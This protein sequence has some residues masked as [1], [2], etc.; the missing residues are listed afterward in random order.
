[1]S[2]EKER[3]SV[4]AKI[5]DG[6]VHDSGA[7]PSKKIVGGKNQVWRCVANS[8]LIETRGVVHKNTA[9]GSARV[10]NGDCRSICSVRKKSTTEYASGHSLLNG[11]DVYRVGAG[12]QR[13]ERKELIGWL[14]VDVKVEGS[15]KLPRVSD[16]EI[17]T[18]SNATASG[19]CNPV[20]SVATAGMTENPN[21]LIVV[22]LAGIDVDVK[23][24][25]G[26]G[27]RPNHRHSRQAESRSFRQYVA[28]KSHSAQNQFTRFSCF[29]NPELNISSQK[30]QA[31]LA[32][33]D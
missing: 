26:G 15:V 28:L 14:V 27:C 8:N 33:V 16:V 12:K 5:T 20:N 9:D 17:L 1:M 11:L 2:I 13:R 32:A 31:E 22:I 18:A 4:L 7:K 6:F 19:C 21:R 29:V 25:L 23:L 24:R 30:S 3:I 10:A